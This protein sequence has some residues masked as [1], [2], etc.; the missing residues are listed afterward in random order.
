MKFKPR[1]FDEKSRDHG[2]IGQ[3]ANGVIVSLTKEEA[4]RARITRDAEELAFAI[5]L[6][7]DSFNR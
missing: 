2:A 6:E 5:L 1:K 7:N 3:Q 4:F